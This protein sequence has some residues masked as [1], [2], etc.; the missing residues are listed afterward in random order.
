M[1][2]IAGP[3]FFLCRAGDFGERQVYTMHKKIQLR[4]LETRG[5]QTF[6]S[7][8]RFYRWLN[9]S[10]P[11]LGDKMPAKLIETPEG[12]QLVLDVL[13]RIEHGVFS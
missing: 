11:A 10:C 7:R 2:R 8:D 3:V 5:I 1:Q 9:I 6:E 12:L 4:L 13:G